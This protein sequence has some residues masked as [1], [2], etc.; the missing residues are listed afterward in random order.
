MN[1]EC[2]EDWGH[3]G[4]GDTV[5]AS[6]WLDDLA[7]GASLGSLGSLALEVLLVE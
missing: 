4:G 3:T 2:D 1:Q 5:D 6:W 7:I